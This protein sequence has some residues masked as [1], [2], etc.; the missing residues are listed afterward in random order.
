MMIR[1]IPVLLLAQLTAYADGTLSDD[2][3][4]SSDALGYDLQYRVYL[5]EGHES[6][7]DLPVI[8]VT[9]GPGYIQQGKMP[10]VLNRLIQRG[11]IEPVIAVFVDARDPDN[12]DVNR[13]NQQFFCNAEY[14]RFFEDELIPTIAASYPAALNRERRYILGVSFGALNAACFGLGG[15]RTFGGI[16]MQSPAMHPLPGLLPAYEKSPRLPLRV[17]LSTGD[18][19]DNEYTARRFRTILRDKGYDLQFKEVRGEHNWDNWRPLVY[20]VLEFFFETEEQEAS[21]R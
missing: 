3:R 15:Y 10:R 16:A 1:W 6:L 11:S 17:F 21:A 19:N 13:R 2:I 14:L 5:P 12:L 18:R 8:Y 9:D 20:D 4:I 7:G